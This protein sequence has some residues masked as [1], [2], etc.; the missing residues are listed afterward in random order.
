[1]SKK[2]VKGYK[3]KTINISPFDTQ[4]TNDAAGQSLEDFMKE[5]KKRQ[6]F[7]NPQSPR[8]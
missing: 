5:F 1:M 4:N 2:K 3:P 6:F 7:N 8:A